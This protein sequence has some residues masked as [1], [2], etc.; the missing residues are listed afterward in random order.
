MY[1]FVLI[2]DGNE[3]VTCGIS[4]S[5]LNSCWGRDTWWGNRVITIVPIQFSLI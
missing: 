4:V 2:D 3:E 5:D 1:D